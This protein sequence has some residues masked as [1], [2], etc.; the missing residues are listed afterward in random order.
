M[1]GGGWR[2]GITVGRGRR[3]RRGCEICGGMVGL[4]L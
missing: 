1:F 2:R 4:E 3:S